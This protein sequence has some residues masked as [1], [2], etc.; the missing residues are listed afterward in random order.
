VALPVVRLQ[1][2]Y[3]VLVT[4]AFSQ[5]ILQVVISQSAF[6]GGTQGLVRVPTLA[7]PGY[8]FLRDFKLGYYYVALGLLVF[9]TVCLR[10]IVRSDF[11][12]SIRALRD[13][14]DYGVARGI[15]I[16]WQRLKVLVASAVFAGLAGGFYAVY[17]RVASPEVF[18]FATSSLILSMVLVGGV[19]TIYGPILA[20]LVLTLA[21]EALANIDGLAEGRFML[22]AAAMI[23]C[24]RFLPSGEI[25]RLTLAPPQ[26]LRWA[27][28][29]VL[30][31][32]PQHL[33]LAR[34]QRTQGKD[35]TGGQCGDHAPQ[36][37]GPPVRIA[38]IPAAAP[39]RAE[40]SIFKRSMSP[41]KAGMGTGSRKENARR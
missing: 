30:S 10:A 5:L 2:I 38:T 22:I 18:S 33:R 11:G 28:V 34:R 36:H 6:T 31:G 14:E 35:Q 16:A 37:D 24:L 19:A 39:S 23:L 3:V 12:I 25:Y 17:L 20:A 21:S 1:G 15:P 40:R 8:N 4:F 26:D 27:L 13:N 9:T 41:A 32:I 29:D 7:L